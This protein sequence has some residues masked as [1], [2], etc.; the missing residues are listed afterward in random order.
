MAH[1]V[2]ELLVGRTRM[3][4]ATA[5]GG[6]HVAL[7][8]AAGCAV[9]AVDRDRTAIQT[10]HDRFPEV[11]TVPGTFGSD[12][13]ASRATEFAP[14]F[15][16]MDLGVSSHHFDLDARGFS[17]RS[18]VPL[19]MR[20]AAGTGPSAADLLNDWDEAALTRVF[21]DYG[22]ERRARALAREVVRRRASQE[23]KLSDDF[24]AAIRHILGPRSGPAEFARLFQAVRI[25]VNDEL[26]ELERGLES[27]R[28]ALVPTG[29]LAVITYHSG[30]DRTVKHAFRE[31]SRTCVCPPR[32]PVCTCRGQAFGSLMERKPQR[33]DPAEIEKNPRARS[34]KLRVFIKANDA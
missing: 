4:D 18:G 23:F 14:D 30:E 24:V 16:L 26:G 9:L 20:M 25:A 31:W 13:V 27:M 2:S 33:P 34:A 32:Y 22:D 28:K 15:V 29:G 12:E 8:L 3:L 17:F 21:R 5:G 10:I 1:Q 11:L 19:D 6:G 7:G